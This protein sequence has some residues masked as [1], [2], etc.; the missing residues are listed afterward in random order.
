MNEVDVGVTIISEMLKVSPL[1]GLLSWLVWYFTKQI[2]KKQIE[3]IELQKT[4][5][6][7]HTENIEVINKLT[8]TIELMRND[9]QNI[10][11]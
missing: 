3:N 9:I 1:V 5:I 6:E 2:D 4:M 7:L 11:K 8:Q 10:R